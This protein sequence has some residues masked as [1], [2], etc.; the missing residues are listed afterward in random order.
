MVDEELRRAALRWVATADAVGWGVEGP[1]EAEQVRARVQSLARGETSDVEG[2]GADTGE[3]PLGT[4]PVDALFEAADLL[5]EA[6]E[7]SGTRRKELL[8]AARGWL[9]I[10]GGRS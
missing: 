2:C 6:A 8:S 10:A 5:T 3:R 7:A 4:R 9:V 1:A